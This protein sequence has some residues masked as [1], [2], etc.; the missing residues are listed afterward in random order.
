MRTS[1]R[2]AGETSTQVT[3]TGLGSR[4]PSFPMIVNA[5]PLASASRKMRAVAAFTT[6]N[7]YTP[8]STAR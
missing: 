2:S 4:P 7:R 8:L 3:D 1:R 5:P 6:R